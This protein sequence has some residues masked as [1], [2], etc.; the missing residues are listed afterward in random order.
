MS[1]SLARRYNR[2]PEDVEDAQQEAIVWLVE[3]IGKYRFVGD[4]RAT[5]HIKGFLRTVVASRVS[6]FARAKR[7]IGNE[8]LTREGD[9][10]IYELR[11]SPR[12]ICI[13]EN[14]HPATIVEQRD[15]REFVRSVVAQLDEATQHLYEHLVNGASTHEAA[16]Q[17]NLSYHQARR[18]GLRLRQHL[19]RVVTPACRGE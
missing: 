12:S 19:E 9:R 3:A 10:L 2:S 8:R 7:N 6:N 1:A 15:L 14:D 4:A 16:A 5:H 11:L 18:R 17:M 13:A